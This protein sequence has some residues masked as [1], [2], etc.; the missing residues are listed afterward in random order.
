MFGAVRSSSSS[1]GPPRKTRRTLRPSPIS[2]A[3]T[4]TSIEHP[5]QRISREPPRIGNDRLSQ[6]IHASLD[7]PATNAPVAA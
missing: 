6:K 3:T 7:D 1:K 2:R 5:N 4:A